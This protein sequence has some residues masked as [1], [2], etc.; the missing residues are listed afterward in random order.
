LA[1]RFYP[2]DLHCFLQFA[3][4]KVPIDDARHAVRRAL[5]LV[6]IPNKS[7]LDWNRTTITVPLGA[8]RTKVL[9]LRDVLEE[10]RTIGYPHSIFDASD[11]KDSFFGGRFLMATDSSVI[12]IKIKVGNFEKDLQG[13]C[14]SAPLENELTDD[15][16]HFRKAACE[17]SVPPNFYDCTRHYRSYLQSSVSLVD[18]FLNRYVELS[19]SHSG[20]NI[21]FASGPPLEERLDAWVTEFAP[22]QLQSFKDSAERG[23]FTLIR[24][25]RNKFVHATE[26][27]IG[28]SLPALPDKLNAVRRGIGGL[29]LK[30]RELAGQPTLGFIEKLR[31]APLVT[32]RPKPPSEL[33]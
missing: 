20:N 10:T 30:M 19:F 14:R 31:A 4:I 12:S 6:G 27:Y 33:D 13:P 18:C 5:V 16:L 22:N 32:F 26:P 25:A 8:G 24:K 1:V 3:P 15:I 17:T 2:Q 28:I 11:R 23:K 9:K 29:L 7:G 21:P